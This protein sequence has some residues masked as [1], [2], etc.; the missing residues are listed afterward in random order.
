[1]AMGTM[2]RKGLN[3]L[4]MGSV[5]SRV[6]VN[7]PADVLVLKAR[8]GAGSARKSVLLAFDGSE[9]SERAL[10]R[11]C[12]LSEAEGAKVTVLY[13]IP[14]YEEMLEF[15]KTDSIKETLRRE[16]G[17][18][19]EGAASMA[20]ALGVEARVEADEGQ[21]AERVVEAAKRLGADLIVMGTYGHRGVNRAIMGS[22]AE[23]VIINAPCPVLVVR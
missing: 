23:R 17:R 7:S 6:I 20:A 15:F 18:I 12:R 10:A 16:A 3:R 2:G 11:A 1:V 14:R 8:R 13:V 19:V 5:T 21:A 22:T 9:F 4:I